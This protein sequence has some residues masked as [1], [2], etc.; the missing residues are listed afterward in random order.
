M[1]DKIIRV[2]LLL[3]LYSTLLGMIVSAV[4]KTNR[5]Y[6]N[7]P[8]FERVETRK[9]VKAIKF[10]DKF[11][12]VSL[13]LAPLMDEYIELATKYDIDLSLL[14]ENAFIAHDDIYSHHGRN[15]FGITFRNKFM[16]YNHIL[17]DNSVSH[18][19]QTFVK[20][21][22]YHELFH[23]F[24]ESGHVTNPKHPYILRKGQDINIE[25]AIKN[26]DE[27]EIE[28]YFRFLKKVQEKK[29]KI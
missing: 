20:V 9:D 4:K 15:A 22:L 23:L 5:F 1:R 13:C 18:A 24:S 26:F 19:T 28:E 16:K 25:Y 10:G 14:K 3:A 11:I 21:V 29:I 17:I 27:D 2:V 12:S 7:K 8:K 6:E